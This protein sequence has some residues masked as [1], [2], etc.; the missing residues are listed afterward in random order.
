MRRHQ[1]KRYMDDLQFRSAC[2]EKAA[3]WRRNNPEKVRFQNVKKDISDNWSVPLR[4][5]SKDVVEAKLAQL[6]VVRLCRSET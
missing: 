3:E 2:R 1:K 4:Y 6:E 5:I